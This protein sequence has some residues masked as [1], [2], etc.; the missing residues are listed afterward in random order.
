MA[1]SGE[2]THVSDTGLWVA[3][4]RAMESERPDALFHDPYAR[5]L[6][7]ARGEAIVK[8]MPQGLTQAWAMIVR[9]QVFDE[10][11][12]RLVS[13]DGIDE[14][15]NLACGL[16]ARPYRLALPGSLR[17]TDVDFPDV[18][19]YKTGALQGEQPHCEY[20]A[21]GADLSDPSARAR[22]LDDVAARSSRVLVITE[23]LLIYLTEDQVASLARDLASRPCFKHWL[24]DLANPLLLQYMNRT[25]GKRLSDSP[26]RFQFAP[27]E[28]PA[29]FQAAGWKQSIYMGNWDEAKR[30]NRRMRGAWLWDLLM[31]LAPPKRREQYRMFAGTLLLERASS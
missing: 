2:I 16:D 17:W 4:Y 22:V 20:R 1:G 30:L 23:G 19:D 15:L 14:V 26:A 13:N 29:F 7:G 8:A 31:S 5:K 28:G 25:W 9:T 6:A 21:V 3:I 27:Q 24:T 18:I 11:L 10:I 12:L